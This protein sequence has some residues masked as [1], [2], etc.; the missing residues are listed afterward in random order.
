MTNE[1]N[2]E[3]I[4]DLLAQPFIETNNPLDL[5]DNDKPQESLYQGLS[6]KRQ[7][8]AQA[9]A[10]QIDQNNQDAIVSYGS[11]AQKQLSH[12]S[13]EMISEVKSKDLGEIGD[14]LRELMTRLDKSDPKE[15]ASNNKDNR[16]IRWFKQ[17]RATVYELNAKYQDIGYQIDRIGEALNQQ[18]NTL[19]NDNQKLEHLYQEN[20]QYFEALNVFIA[21]AQLKLEEIQKQVLPEMRQQLDQGKSQ[22][23]IQE[24]ADLEEFANRLEKRIYDLQLSRQITIQQAPQIRLI[25]NTNQNLAEKIQASVNTAIP[26]WKNQIAIQLSLFRQK[27]ALEAQQAVNNTTN[28][29]LRQNADMLEQ[30]TLET[31]R[32]SERGIVDIESL[33]HSQERLLHTIEESLNIQQEGRMKRAEA[34]K[35]MLEMEKQLKEK[36]LNQ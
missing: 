8:Q 13:H 31:A 28:Q 30:S 15:L 3:L 23:A 17:Q 24:M 26:L 25:Q 10:K 2:K 12:F 7:K 6:E 36:L 16:I 29:L 5:A 27:D 20:Y 1:D 32:Q 9:L 4:D 34:E 18:K 14:N 22:M 11:Q 35:S 19:L 33:E 21:G